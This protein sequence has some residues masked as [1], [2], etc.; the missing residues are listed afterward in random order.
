MN[1]ADC[2]YH[3]WYEKSIYLK[4]IGNEKRKEVSSDRS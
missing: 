4:Y 1:F 2:H 3:S